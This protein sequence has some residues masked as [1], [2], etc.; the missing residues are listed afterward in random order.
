MLFAIHN[1]RT[2]LQVFLQLG[3]R[4]ALYDTIVE[5]TEVSINISELQTI[6]DSTKGQDFV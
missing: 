1:I 5:R 4:S 3:I 2:T 6:K